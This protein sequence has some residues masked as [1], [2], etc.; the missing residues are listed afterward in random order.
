MFVITNR[1]LRSNKEGL[2][3]FGPKQ[4]PEGAN[5]LR[6]VEA[7][8]VRGKWE[9]EIIPNKFTKSIRDRM[10]IDDTSVKWGSD[11]AALKVLERVRTEYDNL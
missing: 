8:K 5:E 7:K 2:E 4:S 1:R 6:L 9:T 3:K 11:Y 10:G